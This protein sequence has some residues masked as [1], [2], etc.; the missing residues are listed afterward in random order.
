M[1]LTQS[2]LRGSVVFGEAIERG[3]FEGLPRWMH[4]VCVFGH[5]LVM[6]NIAD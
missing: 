6:F 3:G 2:W 4:K 1:L 5:V